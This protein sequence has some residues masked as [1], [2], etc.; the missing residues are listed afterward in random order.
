[1]SL[2]L[3]PSISSALGSAV[4]HSPELLTLIF[5]KLIKSIRRFSE[6]KGALRLHA[7]CQAWR[8]ARALVRKALHQHWTLGCYTILNNG[9]LPAGT[10][11]ENTSV[12]VQDPD[13]DGFGIG[14]FSH[15]AEGDGYMP[16]GLPEMMAE[17]MGFELRWPNVKHFTGFIDEE[18]GSGRACKVAQA[19]GVTY[20][21]DRLG[22]VAR[23][24]TSTDPSPSHVWE[25]DM[26]DAWLDDD[27]SPHHGI[28]LALGLCFVTDCDSCRVVALDANDLTERF[29]FGQAELNNPLGIAWRRGLLWVVDSGLGASGASDG[30]LVAY[31]FEAPGPLVAHVIEGVSF[32]VG[33]AAAHSSLYVTCRDERSLHVFC[34]EDYLAQGARS[35]LDSVPHDVHQVPGDDDGAYHFYDL[36]VHPDL[37]L[38]VVKLNPDDTMAVFWSADVL[39]CKNYH[40]TW[41]EI[42]RR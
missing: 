10:H 28:A 13:G 41:Q 29:S 20:V 11:I 40:D 22:G 35:R 17:M 27:Q 25:M 32:P 9:G 24:A 16:F 19:A 33:V 3:S 12:Y 36:A 34:P 31:S 30:K 8:G 37:P 4:L 23:F 26:S 5:E 38:A 7:L 1:M 6:V 42:S 39:G 21:A 18:D 15:D 14:F 2:S